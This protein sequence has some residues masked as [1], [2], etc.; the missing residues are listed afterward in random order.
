MINNTV[1]IDT[2]FDDFSNNVLANKNAITLLSF[3]NIET[4]DSFPKSINLANLTDIDSAGLNL[5]VIAREFVGSIEQEFDLNCTLCSYYPPGGFIDWHTNQNFNYYNA[6]CTFS[7]TGESGFEYK[8]ENNSVVTVNDLIG[9]SVKKT[10]WSNNPI[11]W[12]RAYSN[13]DRITC[14]FS[15]HDESKVDAFI[16]S[17]T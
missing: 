3:D 1:I 4:F 17:I 8:D 16:G 5:A 12:H 2:R 7:L 15:S 9:W 13:D 6:I 10:Y 11:V 14:A